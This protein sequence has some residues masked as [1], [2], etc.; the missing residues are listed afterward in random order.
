VKLNAEEIKLI[1]VFIKAGVDC[2]N[3]LIIT[4][5]TKMFSLTTLKKKTSVTKIAHH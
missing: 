5:Y 3:K 1:L 4:I 2:R